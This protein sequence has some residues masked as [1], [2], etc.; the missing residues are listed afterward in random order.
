MTI[1]DKTIKDMEE[2]RDKTIEIIMLVR[3]VTFLE[4]IFSSIVG[5]IVFCVSYLF[6]HFTN[7]QLLTEF[8]IF[9]GV[10]ISV[11]IITG[12][13]GIIKQ[14]LMLKEYNDKDAQRSRS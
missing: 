7:A 11:M 8:E 3:I 12:L 6:F 2:T 4:G 13:V 14:R 1:D 9:I 5:V 10:V